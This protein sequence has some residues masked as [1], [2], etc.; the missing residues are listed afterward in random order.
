MMIREKR[1]HGNKLCN[2]LPIISKFAYIPF[3]KECQCHHLIQVKLYMGKLCFD[4]DSKFIIWYLIDYSIKNLLWRMYKYFTGIYW[5]ALLY[6]IM[7][8]IL[9]EQILSFRR[10]FIENWFFVVFSDEVFILRIVK[11]IIIFFRGRIA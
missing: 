1:T 3:C 5:L 4:R 11:L 9:W 7:G 10:K 2:T 6:L 8:V